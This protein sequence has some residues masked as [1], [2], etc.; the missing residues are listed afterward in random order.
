MWKGG[1]GNG[2][3]SRLA[4][5]DMTSRHS[6]ERAASVKARQRLSQPC[7]HISLYYM[8]PH[9]CPRLIEIQ[10]CP[11][12]SSAE[13]QNWLMMLGGSPRGAHPTCATL[14]SSRIHE[15][16]SFY[17]KWSGASMHDREDNFEDLQEL[18]ELSNPFVA[19]SLYRS[20]G[21]L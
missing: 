15:A 6:N 3:R 12:P 17:L 11:Y 20:R 14:L 5:R 13:L 19:G 16:L 18:L 7:G 9:T 1:Q 8:H 4:S 10:G 2:V 21:R